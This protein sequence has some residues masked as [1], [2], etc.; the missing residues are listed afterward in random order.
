MAEYIISNQA[1]I[2]YTPTVDPATGAVTLSV[3]GVS[4]SIDIYD[5]D[6]SSGFGEV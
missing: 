5:Y 4:G 2:V 3:T 6:C 1:E